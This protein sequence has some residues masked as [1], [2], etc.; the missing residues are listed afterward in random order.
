MSKPA[1]HKLYVL[2]NAYC[3]VYLGLPTY[4]DNTANITLYVCI[5]VADT[6][7]NIMATIIIMQCT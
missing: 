6:H 7:P 2:F 5:S 3:L 4:V 1:K